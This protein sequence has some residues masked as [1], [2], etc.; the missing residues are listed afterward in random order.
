M[1]KLGISLALA[2]LLTL[3]AAAFACGELLVRTWKQARRARR[4]PLAPGAAVIIET[5]ERHVFKG[6]LL[7][8][9]GAYV[10]VILDPGDARMRVP[11]HWVS[12]A[13]P[14][15]RR[16]SRDDES[17]SPRLRAAPERRAAR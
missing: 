7:E 2:A 8:R 11:A 14:R 1:P 4:E 13:R 16:R 10:W 6:T 15:A 12:A 17:E 9:E 5:P 3:V